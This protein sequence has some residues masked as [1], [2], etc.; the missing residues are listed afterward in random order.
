MG[1]GVENVRVLNNN[2][3]NSPTGLEI[4]VSKE[5]TVQKN[6]VHDNT[7]GIGLYHAAAAG[8]GPETPGLPAYADNGPWHIISNN[9]HDN[10]APNIGEG[11]LVKLLPPGGGILLVGVDKVDLQKNTIENNDFYGVAIVDYCLSRRRIA[12]CRRRL[13]DTVP[14]DNQVIKNKLANNHGAPPEGPFQTLAADILEVVIPGTGTNN[15][16]SKNVITNTS[17][18]EAVTIPDP[19]APE[20]N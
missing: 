20:C 13:P 4:T 10:N 19:L 15:C 1:R 12:H 11:S 17:P 18:L 16:F 6:D 9:V 7:V 8:L 2:L 5:I 3:Y 14:D